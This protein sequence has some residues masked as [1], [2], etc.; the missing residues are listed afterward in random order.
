MF[1]LNT[2]KVKRVVSVLVALVL[3]MAG[4]TPLSAQSG[5]SFQI[6]NSV[7]AGGGG[8]SKDAA[9]TFSHESTVGEHAAGTLLRN[10]PFSQTAGL[11]ASNVGLTPTAAPATIS[12]RI[13]SSDS[14]STRRC[15]DQSGWQL[16]WRARRP[17]YH[18]RE[19]LLFIC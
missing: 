14:A 8:Q 4:N 2:R 7:V 16:R 10:P 5:G 15:D 18:R 17:D 12:G 1:N 19:G 6:T 9:N 13:L 3:S 11:W